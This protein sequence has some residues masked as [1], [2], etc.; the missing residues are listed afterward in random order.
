MKINCVAGI[1][2]VV[3]TAGIVVFKIALALGAPWGEYAKGG[4]YP[5]QF[6]P[7]FR[8]VALLQVVLLLFFA[9]VVLVRARIPL[10]KWSRVLSWLLWVVVAFGAINLVLNLITPS[11][12]ERMIWAPVAFIIFV[13]S[14]VVAIK[15]QGPKT[16]N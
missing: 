7:A 12:G 13:S 4:T 3:A 9:G 11:G 5:G 14:L 2:Y 15:G 16:S 1:S 10:R 6:P 8:A